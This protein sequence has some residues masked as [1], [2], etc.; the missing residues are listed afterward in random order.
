M[1]RLAASSKDYANEMDTQRPKGTRTSL[2]K[3]F[4]AAEFMA[5]PCFALAAANVAKVQAA[6]GSSFAHPGT[7]SVSSLHRDV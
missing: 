1:Q 5:L 7:E 2:T 6:K 3:A 4:A